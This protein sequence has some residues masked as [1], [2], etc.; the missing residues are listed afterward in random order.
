M[1]YDLR[2]RFVSA[3]AHP[4]PKITPPPGGEQK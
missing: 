1:L 4:K 3:K 2:M